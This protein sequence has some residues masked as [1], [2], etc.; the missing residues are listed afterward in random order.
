MAGAIPARS[1]A[2]TLDEVIARLS[3]QVTPASDRDLVVVPNE[4]SAPLPVG[5]TAIDH[6][7]VDLLFV[8]AALIDRI[9]AGD[10]RAVPTEAWSERV[11]H[12][13]QAGTVVFDR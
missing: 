12:W 2:M 5:L 7:L 3:A 4:R 13:L 9:L 8:E 1:A 6:R 11:I 10:F